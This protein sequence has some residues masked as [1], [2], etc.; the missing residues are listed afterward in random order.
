MEVSF[1]LGVRKLNATVPD[2]TIVLLCQ[3]LMRKIFHAR[4]EVDVKKFKEELTGRKSK[5]DASQVTFCCGLQVYEELAKKKWL[6]QSQKQNR[7][8]ALTTPH[9]GLETQGSVATPRSSGASK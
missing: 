8:T 1:F 6:E 5:S 3:E 7:E 2:K 4:I 9:K